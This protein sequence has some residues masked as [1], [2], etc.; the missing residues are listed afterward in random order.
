[1]TVFNKFARSFKSHWLLYLCVIVFGI[2]NLVASSGAHMVQRLL[3]FVLTILVVKRISSLPLRL[4]VAAPFV[5]LTAAD[6]SISLYSWCTFGTTFN[7][8]FAI[9]VLQS[10]PDEVVK[11]LGMYIPY[12][13]A[14]AFLS[15]LFLAVI[16]KYDVSL[17]T[18]KVTG[19]LLLIVI[20]GSL[21]FACQFAYK[22]AKNKKAFS[23]YILAS[24][25]ATYTPFFNLNYFALAAKEHQRLLSIA[26][27][28]PYFQLSVRD[29]G[30]DTYVLIVGESVRVDN[31]SLY[32]YT[33]STT[34]QVE[35]QRKQIKLFNQAISG[36][37][38][39]ALSVPLS[40]TADSVLSHD[41]HNYPDNIINMANQAGF[42]T[43]W[44][45]S[46]SAFRQNGTAVTSIA[47]RAME[48]V[49]VRGFDEL[50]L[51]HLSQ[52]LQQNTQQ[53][54]L[55]V[56]HLNGSHEP[57]CS[58]YPQSS[59]VFQPQD[60]QDACY[61][62]SI[63]YTDSLL[64]QVFELLKDRRASV[65]YFAD[66]GLERD[67]TKKNVYFHGGREASQ[68]AY[69]VPMFI[70]YSPVLGDGVDRTTENN[71][72]STAYNN[73]LI[74]AWMGVTK[75]EQPQTLEEVIAHYKGDSRVVD[76]NHDVFDYVMLRKEFTEDK[77]GNPTPEGQG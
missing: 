2:T 12:L 8:G 73:Y 63:H 1:M 43:F 61:D 9:S 46:Q 47:M 39:T 30:I 70:W 34:P 65:M 28:V 42:Q 22:D 49:Y 17:P 31:M 11:M 41:I 6:M 33:R 66:H 74:N 76:A 5:L 64:G 29:T 62:N 4:L 57:A 16:I 55:I 75:P 26:N 58:A 25:F 21:F 10:D 32:G 77:Q 45:S 40:L 44:L 50:L 54:K 48:T 51:P 24:R 15:L 38:Y 35:A 20:S 36:A 72:F 71:I 7:D 67:P 60:D 18:K 14:F 69:H 68:Q 59:A 53:K 3:F 13:C 19:I 37:P 27:T 23:P 56:L 52:A